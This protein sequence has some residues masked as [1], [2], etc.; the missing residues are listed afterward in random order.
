MLITNIRHASRAFCSLTLIPCLPL[1][2][3]AQC[4]NRCALPPKQDRGDCS[5]V[6][7]ANSGAIIEGSIR[8]ADKRDQVQVYYVNK[9]PFKYRYTFTSSFVPFD[10]ETALAFLKLIPD[11]G[12]TVSSIVDPQPNNTA[13]SA[14]TLGNKTKLDEFKARADIAK[15]SQRGD[16][17]LH[18]L[19]RRAHQILQRNGQRRRLQVRHSEPHR[20]LQRCQEAARPV[21]QPPR[22]RRPLQAP[23]KRPHLFRCGRFLLLRFCSHSRTAEDFALCA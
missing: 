10:T 6:I 19:P 15:K 12:S 1:V 14:C 5:V 23:R 7:D 8:I 11:F 3:Y 17:R 22:P 20:P 9:N 13:A 4:A 16:G 2:S 21:R 18:R